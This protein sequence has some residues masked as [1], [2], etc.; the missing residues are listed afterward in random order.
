MAELEPAR[1]P[2]GFCLR[3]SRLSASGHLETSP[4]QI[5]EQFEVPGALPDG[6]PTPEDEPSIVNLFVNSVRP[7][8]GSTTP[9]AT[10]EKE[11]PTMEPYPA[12][13]ERFDVDQRAGFL[14]L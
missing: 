9:A 10:K 4:R 5:R 14:S 11:P 12:L 7:T 8:P 6:Q 3:Y 1:R 2:D 13:L